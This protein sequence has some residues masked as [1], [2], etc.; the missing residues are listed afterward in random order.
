MANSLE[1]KPCPVIMPM[2]KPYFLILQLENLYENTFSFDNSTSMA[3][4]LS[5]SHGTEHEQSPYD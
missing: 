4:I 1:T 3:F 2:R 5:N